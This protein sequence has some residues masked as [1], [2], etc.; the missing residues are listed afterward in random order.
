MFKISP[1]QNFDEQKKCLSECGGVAKEGYFAYAMREDNGRLLGASQFEILGDAGYLTDLRPAD[2]IDDFEAMF[3]LGRATMNF[4]DLC[5]IHKCRASIEAG[6][7]S[8]LRAIGFR[9]TEAGDLF[10][11]MTGFFDGNCGGHEKK[12][13]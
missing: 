11:D 13:N 1:I 10:V 7:A 3:I 5:G 4:I 9:E 12:D 2:G 6:D 8:L